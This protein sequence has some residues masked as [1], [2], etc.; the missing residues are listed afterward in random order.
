M[1]QDDSIICRYLASTVAREWTGISS[2]S[3]SGGII[4]H[5]NKRIIDGIYYVQ[6]VC[7]LVYINRIRRS[8]ARHHPL[9]KAFLHVLAQHLIECHHSMV[10]L[11]LAK[12]RCDFLLASLSSRMLIFT[13]SN[14]ISFAEKTSVLA[15]CSN[16]RP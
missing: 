10:R 8:N 14:N 4:A 11:S 2:C 6:N 16:P 9:S 3:F 1:A 7:N 12:C 5:I 15:L 13:P